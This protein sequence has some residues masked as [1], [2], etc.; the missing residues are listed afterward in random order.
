MAASRCRGQ[1]RK[2]TSIFERIESCCGVPQS[3]T[4]IE[5][6][7]WGRKPAHLELRA[8]S[9]GRKRARGAAEDR[10]YGTG[11]CAAV[12]EIHLDALR[13]ERIGIR[14]AVFNDL[15]TVGESERLR[16]SEC[17]GSEIA[18]DDRAVAQADGADI[19]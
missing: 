6:Q 9:I 10:F 3:R 19:L 17:L 7:L 13:E 2:Y 1:C 4:P 12:G 5:R 16:I 11:E 18:E 14:V 8:H 15:Q